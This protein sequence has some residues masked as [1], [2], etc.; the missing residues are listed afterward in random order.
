MHQLPVWFQKLSAVWMFSV[1]LGVPFL[2]FMPRRL[3]LAA[4]C[5]IASLEVFILLTGNYTYFNLLALTLSVPLLDDAYLAGVIPAAW[6][7]RVQADYEPPARVK[8]P[9]RFRRAAFAVL[10]VGIICASAERM[11]ERFGHPLPGADAAVLRP[12]ESFRLVSAYG[13]F[14]V[15]TTERVE[16]IMEG[17]DDGVSWKPY[18]FPYKP[19]D[20]SRAPVW[21][22]PHQPRLDWQMWFAALSN[23]RQNQ[24]L[25]NLAV[26]LLE[27]SPEA[28]ALLKT[29]P[30]PNRP[31]RLLR[32]AAYEY[33]FTTWAE[34]RSTG[35][36]W[37][38]EF[39]GLYLPAGS[40]R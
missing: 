27:G 6:R 16:I 18:E 28:L 34:R 24:W 22:A 8:L 11:L 36:W 15:M 33:H 21:A 7:I 29:N 25:V 20:L 5:A 37:K 40:L 2:I 19:G 10:A 9:G 12:I 35:H 26:R 13:L 31:P 17:S 32:A 38:R 23:Y 39:L 30:F 1:E 4:A 14:A 3:R